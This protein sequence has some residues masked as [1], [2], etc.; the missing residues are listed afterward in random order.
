VVTKIIQRARTSV[1]VIR[2][3]TDT[4][5]R[6][7]N[8][9]DQRI[10]APVDGSR[11]AE[12]GLFAAARLARESGAKLYIAHVINPPE[13]PH[14]IPLS[15]ADLDLVKQVVERNREEA[16]QYLNSL[17]VSLDCKVETCLLIGNSVAHALQTL[18]EQ[19]RINLLVLNAHGFGGNPHWPFGNVAL[20]FLTNSTISLLIVQD[21]ERDRLVETKAE[22]Y[23][24]D[25]LGKPPEIFD[26]THQDYRGVSL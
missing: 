21:F 8:L 18:V 23:A 25:F 3:Y 19:E 5:N 26:G 4:E 17:K 13:L 6:Q 1:L 12:Y 9:S 15:D 22:S 14:R 11:R 10:L 7:A 24:E 2:S 16:S 20:N